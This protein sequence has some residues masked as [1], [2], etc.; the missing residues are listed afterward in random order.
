MS[1]QNK[2]VHEFK[3][4]VMPTTYRDELEKGMT[5]SDKIEYTFRKACKNVDGVVGGAQSTTVQHLQDVEAV[6]S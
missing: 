6:L 4:R 1:S 2:S 5:Q 3:K